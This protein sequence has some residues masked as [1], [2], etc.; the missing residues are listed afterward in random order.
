MVSPMPSDNSV[1]MPAV[2]FKSPPGS[3]PA[4]VTP[5]CSGKSTVSDNSRYES[6]MTGTFDDFTEIFTSSKP[7]SA[8]Y[9]SSRSADATNASGGRRRAAP[10]CR[11]RGCPR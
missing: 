8:K 2:P 5:R 11:G 9:A 4:S 7:T 1:A 3:G 10:R 6:I